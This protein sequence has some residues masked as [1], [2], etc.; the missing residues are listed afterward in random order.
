MIHKMKL[1]QVR[2]KWFEARYNKAFYSY[3][4]H[5]TL[6]EYEGEDLIIATWAFADV[7]RG[8]DRVSRAV[9]DV[10]NGRFEPPLSPLQPE[11]PFYQVTS[12]RP[13]ARRIDVSV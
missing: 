2:P 4:T 9:K 11:D 5:D 7:R 3:I 1:V 6:E 10:M 13:F 12:S 8:C